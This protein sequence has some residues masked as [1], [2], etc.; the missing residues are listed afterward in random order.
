M[1]NLESGDQPFR[2]RL[3]QAQ[4][5]LLVPIDKILFRGFALDRLS[6]VFGRFFVQLDVFSRMIG[7]LRHDP[8]AIIETLAAGP[9]GNLMKI[10]RAQN[11]GLLAIELAKP[12]KQHGADGHVNP[13]LQSVR[14]AKQL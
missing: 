12:S 13:G 8:A 2:R 5:S 3:H 11:G 4:I 14:P 1:R 10:A 7:R 6:A 9:S